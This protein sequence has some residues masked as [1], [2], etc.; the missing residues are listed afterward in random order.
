[1]RQTKCVAT[2]RARSKEIVRH[3]LLASA[4]LPFVLSQKSLIV[5]GP[6]RD[7]ATLPPGGCTRKSPVGSRAASGAAGVAKAERSFVKQLLK[8]AQ[9]FLSKRET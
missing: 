1:M 9:K 5:C 7:P 8:D 3:S 2:V 4:I 6:L